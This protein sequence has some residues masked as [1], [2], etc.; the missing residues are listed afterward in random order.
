MIDLLLSVTIPSTTNL[1]EDSIVNQLAIRSTEADHWAPLANIWAGI[2]RLYTQISGDQ[3]TP[4]G[5]YLSSGLSRD[6]GACVVRFYDITDRLGYEVVDGKRRVELHGSPFHQDT[7]TLPAPVNGNSLPRQIASVV[8]LRGRGAAT[9]P[10]EGAGGIRPKARHTGRVYLGPL[11]SIASEGAANPR[12]T[13]Q[14]RSDA[15]AAFEGFQDAMTDGVNEHCV[16]SREAGTLYPVVSAEMDDS[17]D[18]IRSR[19]NSATL[20]TKRTYAPV[21]A[22]VLGA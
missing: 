16:W 3:V 8:T 1:V 19:K 11:G 18:V 15:C 14:F 6:P 21:P 17:F 7:F 9:A 4:L 5:G 13:S 2:L 10:V 20:R 22:L 12:P